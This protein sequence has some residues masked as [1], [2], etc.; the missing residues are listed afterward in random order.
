MKKCVVTGGAGFIGSHLTRRLLDDGY[1][2]TVIDD[3]SEGKRENL[4]AKHP[5]LLVV[6]AS[7]LNDVS[8]YI[9]GTDV[10]FHF[11][12]LPRLQRS[13]DNP[14]RTHQVNIDG[15]LNLLLEA[16]KHKIRRFIFSSS[17]SVYGIQSRLPFTEN[18][19][20]NP[21]VPY[22]LHK[23]VGEEYCRMFSGL[24]GLGT[25]SLRYFNIYGTRMNPDGAYATLIPKFIKLISLNKTPLIHG[26]G[27]Q[28]RDFTHVSDAVEAN[29]FAAKSNLSGEVFNIGYGKSISVNNVVKYINRLLK[30]NIK[31][32]HGP[33]F[34]ESRVSQA[35]NIKARKMLGWKPKIKF[36]EGIKTMLNTK[37]YA[38]L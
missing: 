33:A 11:A 22:S 28:T 38:R 5:N 8:K 32:I 35:S 30:K 7:I 14:W 21:L 6:K 3:F 17:S 24:W 18:M 31:P 26:D 4:P 37:K 29:I 36:E 27:R 23:L 13:L 25:V 20:P 16:K 34:I 19:K 2:V 12:A 10:I 15:T 9:K 1:K